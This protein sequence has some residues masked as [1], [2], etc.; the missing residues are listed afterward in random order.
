MGDRAPNKL[1]RNERVP[2]ADQFYPANDPAIGAAFPATTHPRNARLP[3]LFQPLTVRTTTFKNRIW[4]SPMCQYSSDGG[5]AT[6][7][8]LVHIGG[9]AT[10]GAGAI[11]LE[12]TAVSPEG[13][14][15]PEDAGLW[16]D[17]QIAPLKRI[18]DF[19][20]A[21]GCVVGVQLAHAGRKA[22]TAAPWVRARRARDAGEGV[23]VSQVAQREEGGWPDEVVGPSDIPFSDMFPKPTPL[24]LDGIQRVVDAFAEATERCKRVGFDFIEIH[25][26]H[27]YLLSSFLSPL[28][29]HRTDAYGGP[30]SNRLRLP[31][32]VAKRVREV[33]GAEKPLFF[34]LSATDWAAGP[35]QDPQSGAWRS[36]GIEQSTVLSRA[37]AEAGIDL[38]DVS[39]GGNWAAQQIPLGP[40]YQVPFAAAIKHAVP[41]LLVGAVGLITDPQQ[42]EDVLKDGKADVVFLARELLRHVDWPLHAARALGVAVHPAVQYE[43]AWG[44]DAGLSGA[45]DCPTTATEEELPAGRDWPITPSAA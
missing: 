44:G 4:V 22:S 25:G 41:G 20:H 2:G 13:R 19:C 12:A 45:L 30:L 39:A 5:H 35:E 28:S 11:L 42:A 1:Y 37:L 29:N 16:T 21:Q 34:R 14:I 24:T 33:W 26:A 3:T 38:V 17:T 36:W 31:L 15:S 8:H 9:F 6:D 43:R 40:G 7:W 18:V 32:E 27:G 10:R 23:P